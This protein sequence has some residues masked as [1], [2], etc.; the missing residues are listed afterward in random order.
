MKPCAA[1]AAVSRHAAALAP[2][3]SGIPILLYR[4]LFLDSYRGQIRDFTRRKALERDEFFVITVL[5][6]DPL[7]ESSANRR[8]EALCWPWRATISAKP[9][10]L[11]Q[12]R[13]AMSHF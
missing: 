10:R 13:S 1:G 12:N 6:H 8:A 11:T 9:S 3:I 7:L 2:Q 4:T 5:H